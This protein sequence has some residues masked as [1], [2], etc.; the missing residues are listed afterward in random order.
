MPLRIE[1]GSIAAGGF[2]RKTSRPRLQQCT[3]ATLACAVV[4][5]TFLQTSLRG[6]IFATLATSCYLC[7]L[8]RTFN[9]DEFVRMQ[10]LLLTA[11]FT[12]A[13]QPAAKKPKVRLR[14]ASAS[15]TAMTMGQRFVLPLANRWNSVGTV[16]RRFCSLCL[17]DLCVPVA[18]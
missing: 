7:F 17:L 15:R 4:H 8:P 2:H 1:G 6:R 13:M 3:E 5:K 11:H 16:M 12:L 14:A 9:S 18:T 10:K